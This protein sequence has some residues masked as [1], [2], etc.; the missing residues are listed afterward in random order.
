MVALDVRL[1]SRT[2]YPL[3]RTYEMRNTGDVSQEWQSQPDETRSR[4]MHR[5]SM[6]QRFPQKLIPPLYPLVLYDI[7]GRLRDTISYVLSLASM[8]LICRLYAASL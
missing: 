4:R 8:Y 2:V 3:L 5:A 1:L 6:H 7:C